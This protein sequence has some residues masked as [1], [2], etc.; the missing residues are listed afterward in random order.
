MPVK[1]RPEKRKHY[2]RGDEANIYLVRRGGFRGVE[3]VSHSREGQD[4]RLRYL[5]HRIAHILHPEHFFEMRPPRKK[6]NDLV[7]RSRFLR[8]D[9]LY[10]DALESFYRTRERFSVFQEGSVLERHASRTEDRRTREAAERIRASGINVN[11]NFMN[12]MYRTKSKMPI[13]AEV[14]DVDPKQIRRS[15][16]GLGVHGGKRRTVMRL[17]RVYEGRMEALRKQRGLPS[18]S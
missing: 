6:G 16:D 7:L 4:L 17:L 15:L 8:P 9:K 14:E 13:F 12:I 10:R 11:T 1:K 5:R 18:P 2:V 3:R